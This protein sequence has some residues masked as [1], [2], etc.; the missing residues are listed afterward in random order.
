MVLT[1]RLRP[2]SGHA[3]RKISSFIW[4]THHRPWFRSKVQLALC[5]WSLGLALKRICVACEAKVLKKVKVADN[6]KS[7]KEVKNM[8]KEKVVNVPQEDDPPSFPD[9]DEQAERASSFKGYDLND[10]S[11][12]QAIG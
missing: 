8:K 7:S 11:G 5:F 4:R 6:L 3:Q 10:A 12:C 2:A 1:R 9:A